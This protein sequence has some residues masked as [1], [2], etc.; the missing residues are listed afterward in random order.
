[1]RLTNALWN[2]GFYIALVAIIGLAALDPSI[3]RKHGPLH[4]S[5]AI[6][7]MVAIIFLVCGI[8]LPSQ[9]L[10]Q[11]AL[12]IRMHLVIQVF[13]FVLMPFAL[14]AFFSMPGPDNW[15]SKPITTGIIIL[16]CMPTTITSCVIFTAAAHGD[17]AGAVFNTALNNLMG[18]VVSPALVYL[19]VQPVTHGSASSSYGSTVMTLG[20]IVALPLFVGQLLRYR[21]ASM[22]TWNIG[23][24]NK[25]V[26]V[27][28]CYIVFCESISA[29]QHDRAQSAGGQAVLTGADTI[30]LIVVLTVAHLVFLILAWLLGWISILDF[31]R[32]NRI[33][34]LFV[35]TEKTVALSVSLI[36]SMYK[37]DENNIGLY[38]LPLSIYHVIL[39][40][41]ASLLI[42]PLSSWVVKCNANANSNANAR[43]PLLY[44]KTNSVS[45]ETI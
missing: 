33:A 11:G 13:N 36:H 3:G 34:I 29:A 20:L 23:W 6:N 30:L 21:F 40:L 9:Q 5:I 16:G 10:K 7:V 37:H 19:L 27:L 39:T 43:A 35:S 31:T 17:E 26:L 32:K 28:V 41:A 18:L 1:V 42:G 44:S 25:L 22:R 24:I 38:S 2:G 4:P 12:N 14:Y 15:F 8:R 45:D